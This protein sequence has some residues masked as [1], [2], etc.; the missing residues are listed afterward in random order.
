MASEKSASSSPLRIAIIGAGIGGLVLAQ[1][2]R[3]DSRFHITVYER[4]SRDG[5]ISH[6]AGFR[7]FLAQEMLAALREQLPPEVAS[8]MGKA[9]GVQPPGGQDLA[10]M[11]EKGNVKIKYMPKDFRDA[12]SVSR[13]KLRTALLVGLD[14][15]VKWEAEFKSYESSKDGVRIIFGEGVTVECDVL[16]GADGAGSKIRKQLLPD[17]TRDSLGVTVLYFK[18]PFT[19]ET[20]AMLP[21]GSGCMVS[22]ETAGSHY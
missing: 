8:Q 13:S 7:I 17:S 4:S 16:V 6:L 11:D 5:N 10:L 20:E 15:F 3:N 19:P 1:L 22:K 12:R 9:I 14:D 18:M 2:L 21:F